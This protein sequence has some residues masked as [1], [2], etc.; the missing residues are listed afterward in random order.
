MSRTSVA[1]TLCLLLL[2]AASLTEA[3]PQFFEAVGDF[4]E[5]VGEGVG[6]FFDGVGDFFSG[7]VSRVLEGSLLC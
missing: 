6:D 4:V 1:L 5:N 3:R 7:T 2:V